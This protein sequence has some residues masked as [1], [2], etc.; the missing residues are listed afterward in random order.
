MADEFRRQLTIG[1]PTRADQEGLDRL[2]AQLESGK[3]IVK[4]IL[5]NPLHAKLYLAHKRAVDQP[6]VAYLG[7]SNLTSA[8]LAGQGELNTDILDHDATEKLAAWF[9]ARL[10]DLGGW[11]TTLR[12]THRERND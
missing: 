8:G 4:F 1:A 11:L 3:L 5:R 7:S 10:D 6:R 9:D 2:K 12:A